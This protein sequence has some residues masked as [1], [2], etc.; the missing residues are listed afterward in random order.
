MN[1]TTKII[2]VTTSILALGIGGYF[3]YR[4]LKKKQ[5]K[6]EAE[7]DVKNLSQKKTTVFKESNVA[8]PNVWRPSKPTISVANSFDG[9][10]SNA[11]GSVFSLNKKSYETTYTTGP[12]ENALIISKM[13]K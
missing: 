1:R 9:D 10:F 6:E 4:Y 12:L 7:K 2:L 5:N 8:V 13:F 3:L 11:T